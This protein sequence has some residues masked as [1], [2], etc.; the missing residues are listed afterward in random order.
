VTSIL[1]SL[2][3]VGFAAGLIYYFI[4]DRYGDPALIQNYV[5]QTQAILITAAGLV[6]VGYI[7]RYM[8]RK[9]GIGQHLGRCQKCGKRIDPG[10]SYCFDHRRDAIW[11]A[12]DKHRLEGSGKFNRSQKRA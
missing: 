11:Q 8:G 6:I 1:T 5:L 9:T 7:F 2:G 4:R 3:W 12:Q 10:E